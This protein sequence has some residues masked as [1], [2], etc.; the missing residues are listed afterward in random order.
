[1]CGEQSRPVAVEYVAATKEIT[2]IEF[3]PVVIIKR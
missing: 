2:R 1:V 3:K